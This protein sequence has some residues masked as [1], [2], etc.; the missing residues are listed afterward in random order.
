MPHSASHR[1]EIEK[2]EERRLLAGV[3]GFAGALDPTFDGDGRG[4]VQFG[5][6]SIDT[7]YASLVQPDGK[8]LLVGSTNSTDPASPGTDIAVARLNADATLDASFGVTLGEN[9]GVGGGLYEVPV[10]TPDDN[11][12]GVALQPDGKIVLVGSIGNADSESG[13]FFGQAIVIRLTPEGTPDGTFGESG[14]VFLPL[15]VDFFGTPNS[16]ARGVALQSDGKIVVV[17]TADVNP[18]TG[19]AGFAAAR[20]HTDGEIDTSFGGNGTGIRVETAEGLQA[21]AL[22]TT[23]DSQDR[24]LLTGTAIVPTSTSGV[25]PRGFF[26]TSRLTRDGF[27]DFSF[28][29]EGGVIAEFEAF[30][31][32][33]VLLPLGTA[34]TVQPDGRILT[35][36][37]IVSADAL[38]GR[39]SVGFA[40]TR[41]FENGEAD[42]SFGDEGKVETYFGDFND[43]DA[44][45]I[46]SNINLLPGGKILLTGRASIPSVDPAL[47]SSVAVV[48]YNANGSLDRTFN[49]TG[50]LILTPDG[51]FAPASAPGETE[52]RFDQFARN[53]AATAAVVPGGGILLLSSQGG[54]VN[55]ARLIADGPDLTASVLPLT[56][57]SA[58]T[59]TKGTMRLRLVNQGSAPLG[60][61][62]LVKLRLSTDRTLSD[63]DREFGSVPVA[64]R[65]AAGSFRQITLSFSFP[66]DPT[67]RGDFFILALPNEGRATGES[68]FLNNTAAS[69]TFVSLAPAFVRISAT[70][71]VSPA[72]VSAAGKKRGSFS[73]RLINEGNITA[74][75]SIL[76]QLLASLDELESGDDRLLGPTRPLRL[77]LKPGAKGSTVRL[78]V[79]APAGTTPGEPMTL[80]LK[81]D[82]TNLKQVVDPVRVIGTGRVIRFV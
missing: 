32:S 68:N 62:V 80:L 73:V 79:G 2:L 23:V 65:L 22:A 74:S 37:A 76:L 42:G 61:S 71:T 78:S 77:S 7:L 56:L 27:D 49:R 41:L 4:V 55:V 15:S 3:G 82:S 12:F 57:R 63:D 26:I 19:T 17:G 8:I 47:Y 31:E 34:I 10:P 66:A 24:I 14:L 81:L 64:A 28:G 59:G 75:G 67:L 18:S 9:G 52:R 58:L 50:K 21:F 60:G 36:G 46:P 25:L 5:A 54:T 1:F 38:S 40:M 43:V 48:R 70:V 53:A 39:V 20:L 16:E 44:L 13:L 69:P 45:A 29:D 33:E 51:T 11:L 6:R 72:T 30:S 35:A